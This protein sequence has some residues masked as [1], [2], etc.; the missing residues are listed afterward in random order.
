MSELPATEK[1]LLAGADRR[2]PRFIVLLAIAGTGVSAWQWGRELG[3]SFA[4]GGGLA[5]VNYRWIV[6]VVDTLVQS[7]RVR[8]TRRTYLKLFATLALLAAGLYVIFTARLLSPVGVL[9]GLSV[10]VVAI[11]MESVY[12]LFL[13][14]R[15]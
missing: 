2:L 9:G 6:A 7:Q 14:G 3:I 13:T 12:Q 11:L 8:P 4:V 5:Y 1:E 10:L 15:E